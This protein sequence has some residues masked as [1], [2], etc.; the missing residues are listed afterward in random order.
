MTRKYRAFSTCGTLTGDLLSF[1]QVLAD[2]KW[3][4]ENFTSPPCENTLP[5]DFKGLD[6]T[7]PFYAINGRKI[8]F[9]PKNPKRVSLDKLRKDVGLTLL[10]Y[11]RTRKVQRRVEGV[12]QGLSITLGGY[13][14]T[15]MARGMIEG[16]MLV[17]INC[18]GN[19]FYVYTSKSELNTWRLC[20]MIDKQL[21]KGEEGKYFDYVQQTLVHVELQR[22]IHKHVLALDMDYVME[23]HQIHKLYTEDPDVAKSRET[24]ELK[25]LNSIFRPRLVEPF[26]SFF[27][28]QKEK[29][30]DGIGNICGNI[31]QPTHKDELMELSFKLMDTFRVAN[32]E[33]KYRVKCEYDDAGTWFDGDYDVYVATLQPTLQ[34]RGQPIYLLYAKVIKFTSNY[35]RGIT[36]ENKYF[37]LGLNMSQTINQYGLYND[38]VVAGRYV[39]KFLEYRT[40]F[41]SLS[42]DFPF[43]NDRYVCIADIYQNLFPFFEFSDEPPQAELQATAERQAKP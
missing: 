39:C 7:V 42:K 23:C 10:R 25:E 21:Y 13:V 24:A 34:P 8:T 32:V 14:F 15:L 41:M 6:G 16:R 28:T 40:Q 2:M 1:D 22:F 3:P 33:F 12:E 20:T 26:A 29:E 43:V 18:G 35:Q 27:K 19:V 37:P 4:G 9:D 17:K 36:I 31:W 5:V 38:Y 30:K 11:A